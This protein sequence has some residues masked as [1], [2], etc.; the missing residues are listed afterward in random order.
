MEIDNFF[1]LK[2][3]EVQDF[4]E[5]LIGRELSESEYRDVKRKFEFGIEC[6]GEILQIAITDTVE[7]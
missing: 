1:I 7:T 6:W 4:V 5:S 2:K 3:D